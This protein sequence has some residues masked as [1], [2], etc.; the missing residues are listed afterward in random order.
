MDTSGK[1]TRSGGKKKGPAKYKI[2]NLGNTSPVTV[3]NLVGILERHLKVKTKKKF[4]DM[5]GNGDVPYTHA[6]ISY[7]DIYHRTRH[8]K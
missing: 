1:S 3:P 4:V 7:M 2:F 5:S 6:N 8:Q